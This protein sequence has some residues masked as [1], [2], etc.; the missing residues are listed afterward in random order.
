MK[1]Y[2]LFGMLISVLSLSAQDYK[3]LLDNFN[4]W[5][6]TSCYNGCYTDIYYT[7]G[8]TLV[9]NT[10]YKILDGFHYI[11]RTFLLRE[12]VETKKIYM[13]LATREN[14]PEYLLY[15]FALNTGDSIDIKNPISPF[16]ADA[17]FYTVDSI[18]PQPLEDGNYYRHF[19][20]SP[21]ASN[22][23]SNTPATW[24]EGVGSLSL[25][26]APGGFPDIN[27]AGQL[28]CFFKN[29]ELFYS[30]MDSISKCE[31]LIL[32]IQNQE[33]LPNLKM[34]TLVKNGICEMYNTQN[35]KSVAIFDLQGKKLITVE[36]KGAFNYTLDFSG[37]ASGLYLVEALSKDFERKL[38]KVVVD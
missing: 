1:N 28:S 9:E 32:N 26:N 6:L 21:S 23:I 13:K 17:G 37:F 29:A 19:Y 30:N 2:T 33:Q 14:N 22:T 12:N 3:P 8:D 34:N 31:P 11:S 24:V 38:F 16:P 20:L 36:P 27:G 4:E 15:D 10:S 35:L 25:I 7:D 5:H 18:I